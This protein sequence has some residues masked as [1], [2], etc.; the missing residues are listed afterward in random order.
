[1]IAEITTI[2]SST[3]NQSDRIKANIVRKLSVCQK[4]DIVVNVIRKTNGADNQATIA[5][6]IPIIANKLRNTR[7]IVIIQSL[8]RCS[9]SNL[10]LSELSRIVVILRSFGSF[11]IFCI[12]SS[13]ISHWLIRSTIDQPCF[14]T[15]QIVTALDG[16]VIFQSTH[17][18]E[19]LDKV[20]LSAG[21]SNTFAISFKYIIQLFQVF[22]ITRFFNVSISKYLS[23]TVTVCLYLSTQRSQIGIVKFN[24]D[25]AELIVEAVNHNSS[26][27]LGSN[28]TLNSVISQP[29][30]LAS[31]TRVFFSISSLI[32]LAKSY[33]SNQLYFHEIVKVH[34]GE[35]SRDISV[36]T[37]S[38]ASVG[39]SFLVKSA[40][41]FNSLMAVGISFVDKN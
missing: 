4:N 27:F 8:T 17:L 11:Q 21:A 2:A 22:D 26:S 40:L 41:S 18:Y 25:I 6:F 30:N 15:T 19:S 16:S 29:D 38:F 3:S 36:T 1:M 23:S 31:D 9:R 5:S 13:F 34:I 28:S 12:S 33:S 37:G 35:S 39:K 20:V 10:I 32:F 7:I 14:L 24:H